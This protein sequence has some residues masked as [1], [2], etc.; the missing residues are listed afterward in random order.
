MFPG[1]TGNR[2]WGF[3]E[4]GNPGPEEVNWAYWEFLKSEQHKSSFGHFAQTFETVP[5]VSSPE[6]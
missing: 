3:N 2:F 6:L 4:V 5:D 1:E